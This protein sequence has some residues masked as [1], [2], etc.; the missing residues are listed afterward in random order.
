MISNIRGVTL[1]ELI[2]VVSI[3]AILVVALG[4]QYAGWQGRYNVESTVRQIHSDMLFARSRAMQYGRNH[5]FWT[6]GPTHYV[7]CDD[8]GNGTAAL[9]SGDGVRQKAGDTGVTRPDTVLPTYPKSTRH[10]MS[11][12]TGADFLT[13]ES[14]GLI[15]ATVIPATL[16]ISSTYTPDYDC[17]SITNLKISLGSWMTGGGCNAK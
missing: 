13:F 17:I 14:N 8:D 5:Y 3:I 15:S 10:D 16:Q 9:R 12:S 2:I 1:V 11:W 7:I 6:T 4:F